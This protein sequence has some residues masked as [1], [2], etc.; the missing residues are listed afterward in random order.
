MTRYVKNGRPRGVAPRPLLERFSEKYL[1]D[2]A[3]GCWIW[4]ASK[5]PRGY[6]RIGVGKRVGKAHRVAFML[7]NGDPSGLHVCH[8]CDNPPCVNPAHL[9]LG[10]AAQNAADRDSKGRTGV[11]RRGEKS[12]AS[13]LSDAQRDAIVAAKSRGEKM[14]P[15]A[16]LLGVAPSTVERIA[17]KWRAKS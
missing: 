3:T 15:I 2:I 5:D 16:R 4:T 7:F 10:T 1:I 9:F 12:T 17:N 13:K 11:Q 14:A 8:H 6:G